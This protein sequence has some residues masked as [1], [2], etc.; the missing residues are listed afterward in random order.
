[1]AKELN[2]VAPVLNEGNKNIYEL[3]KRIITGQGGLFFTLLF[4]SLQTKPLSTTKTGI[5]LCSKHTCT[6]TTATGVA[7]PHT[8]LAYFHFSCTQIKS[9]PKSSTEL[10]FVSIMPHKP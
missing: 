8:Q 7:P 9:K 10:K 5:T 6:A 1:M 2:V 3:I 4:L